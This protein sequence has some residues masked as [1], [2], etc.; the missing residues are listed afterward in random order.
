M[1][2]LYYRHKATNHIISMEEIKENMNKIISFQ[3]LRKN[4]YIEEP[5][6]DRYEYILSNIPFNDDWEIICDNSDFTCNELHC[7]HY[8]LSY[9]Y[10]N[11]IK[12]LK[13]K[14]VKMFSVKR[15]LESR[16]T[17]HIKL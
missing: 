8:A 14:I 5:I 17:K 6:M 13:D 4:K 7:L 11:D 1:I 10:D 16:E 15:Y 3:H 12:E 2:D 9:S